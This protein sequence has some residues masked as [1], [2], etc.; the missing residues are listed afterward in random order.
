M[1]G[2]LGDIFASFG[3]CPYLMRTL[4]A[5]LGLPAAPSLVEMEVDEVGTGVP[6]TGGE[7]VKVAATGASER[8]VSGAGVEGVSGDGV[9]SG[10]DVKGGNGEGVPSQPHV[11]VTKPKFV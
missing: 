10:A 7:G 1:F 4:T 3:P 2:V 9:A 6:R 5:Y 11:A 8:L